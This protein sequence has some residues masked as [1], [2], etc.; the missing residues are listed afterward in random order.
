MAFDWLADAELDPH[1]RRTWFAACCFD[2]VV[3]RLYRIE[4]IYPP[5]YT[6]A[7][8]TLVVS[9]HRRD[10]DVP[11]LTCVLCQREGLHIRWPVPFS[12]SREDLFRRD[13]L[14]EYLHAW[15]RPLQRLL[16]RI[17]LTWFFRAM[18][19]E[20]IRRVREFTLGEAFTEL[21]ARRDNAYWL[22][23]RGRRDMACRN[24]KA[25]VGRRR[26]ADAPPDRRDWGLRRLQDQARTELRP[27]FR[28]TVAG[29]LERFAELLDGGRVVYFAPEG[30][31]SRDGRFGRI[32][33]G[34][35]QVVQR[36]T[37]QP[38]I[39]ALALSY[40]PLR[41]GRLRVIVNVGTPLASYDASSRRL[42]D[43]TI[44]RRIRRLYRLNASH[45]ISRFLVAGP[46]TF[47]TD[48]LAGWLERARDRLVTANVALDP[49]LAASRTEL[50]ASERVDWLRR[51]ALVAPTA[52]GWRNLCPHDAPPSWQRPENAVRY[53]DNALADHL[54]ALAPGL[55]L[56]P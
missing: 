35:W 50:L 39:L 3:S 32:L 30:R 9:N 48:E 15:P 19:V 49:E 28:A 24:P 34:P 25:P 40:D 10:A 23:A 33:A 52:T 16:G 45:L 5:D 7:P 27:G 1:P 47:T 6:L 8:G 56:R 42:F 12:A 22:N 36:A 51:K 54:H 4:P 53:C 43:T 38:P 44:K 26:G 41:A 2:L 21:P 31:N 55:T 13:F 46:A 11:I 18:R 17:P 20:P 14:A 29:Q 37:A